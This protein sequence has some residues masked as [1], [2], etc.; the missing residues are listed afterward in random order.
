M[1]DPN[2]VRIKYARYADDFIIGIS[3]DKKLANDIMNRAKQFL[4]SELHLNIAEKKSC[5][6]SI[7]HRQASFLGFL[8][9]KTPKYLNPVISQK[10]KGK[11]KR[12]RVLKRLKHECIQAEQRELKKIKS[13]LK[14]AI[15]RSL[16]KK[17]SSKEYT[18]N[19][20]D[21]IAHI[22]QKERLKN[23][24]FKDRSFFSDS[25]LKTIMYANKSD[26][27]KEVLD[28]FKTFN[29]SVSSNLESVNKE[30]SD[31][32]TKGKFI[33]ESGQ[34]NKVITRQTDLLI[35]IYAPSEII[36]QRLK[37]KGILSKKGKPQALNSMIRETDSTILTWYSS[38]ARGI[39]NYYRCAD[40]FHKVKSIINYQIRWSIYHT[41]A[42]KYKTS[43]HKLMK[44]YGDDFSLSEDLQN[45]FPSKSQ[46]AGIKKT[47]LIK[48]SLSNPFDVLNKVYLKKTQ[49]SF[50]KCSVEK[51]K[52]IDIEIHHVRKLETRIAKGSMSVK[53]I[54]GKRIE[55]WKAYLIS[56]NRKQIALCH[57]HH[58]MIHQNK[59][60]FK[61]KK[62]FDFN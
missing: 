47:F 55:N 59:L 21:N 12:A 38:L 10:L 46:I 15:A 49:L 23:L 28:S 27:P 35:Q 13:N 18:N 26:I 2:Y 36:K 51:C 22:I 40:N 1:K 16:S 30:I 48:Q 62:I 34:E 61:N 50:D 19:I 53:N 17:Y 6:I 4:E 11:E 39:I 41:L 14:A 58:N 31:A 57:N 52:N 37:I 42:K 60:L 43:I 24:Y 44:K 33:D 7:V 9:K 8:L 45:I 54:K 56:K 32:K 29:Q 5:L 20:I 25:I 3:G